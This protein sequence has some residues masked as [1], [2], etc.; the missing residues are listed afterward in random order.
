MRARVHLA[1][2]RLADAAAD[3]HA[4]LG[5]AEG[6]GAHGYAATAHSVLGM[7][8]LRRGDIA[9]AAQHLA[10]RPAASPSSRPLARTGMPRLRTACR[11]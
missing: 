6:S 11:V 4:G 2:G 10:C 5:I 7:I 3:G 9:A 8:E 1:A